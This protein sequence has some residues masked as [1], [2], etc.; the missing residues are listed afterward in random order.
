M[1]S[2]FHNYQNIAKK[3]S[4]CH[5]ISKTKRCVLHQLS[6]NSAFIT[7]LLESIIPK[8]STSKHSVFWLVSVAEQAGLNIALSE[9]P[10]ADFVAS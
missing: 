7:H 5:V 2:H 1:F 3:L 8:L 10:K 4:L 6:L 9:T